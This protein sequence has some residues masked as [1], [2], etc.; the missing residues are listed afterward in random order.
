ME[1]EAELQ[2][3]RLNN[4]FKELIHDLEVTDIEAAKF[5]LIF[6]E[7]GKVKDHVTNLLCPKEDSIC[8]IIDL[9]QKIFS[10]RLKLT[11]LEAQKLEDDFVKASEISDKYLKN[12]EQLEKILEK[13]NE[14]F[15]RNLKEQT[16]KEEEYDLKIKTLKDN[17]DMDVKKLLYASKKELEE[18][19][20]RYDEEA[21]DLQKQ[22]K[23]LEREY[24]KIRSLHMRE[25]KE[26]R[27]TK[28][29][30]EKDVEKTIERFNFETKELEDLRMKLDEQKIEYDAL[31]LEKELEEEEYRRELGAQ[32][33]LNYMARK[34][35]IHW[36]EYVAR[37]SLKK[38]KRGKVKSSGDK[39]SA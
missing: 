33:L 14:V 7:N 27:K 31:M 1:R 19:T 9:L 30:L 18:S 38:K 16:L 25:E 24:E 2:K 3:E 10:D 29:K 5:L 23:S 32:F 12:I 26:L 11:D 22:Y 6:K 4:I 36:R 34:I 28:D 21:E 39:K 13:E 37:K 20:K 17:F 15:E 35:Q 8:E